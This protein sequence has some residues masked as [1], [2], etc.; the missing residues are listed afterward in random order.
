[1]GLHHIILYINRSDV[2]NMVCRI[3]IV[4]IICNYI[5]FDIK[6]LRLENLIIIRAEKKEQADR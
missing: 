2:A 5:P 4:L 6:L 1:M 3:Y